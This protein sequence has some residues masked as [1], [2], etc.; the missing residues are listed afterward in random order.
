MP[1]PLANLKHLA[2][3]PLANLTELGNLPLANLEGLVNP[4]LANLKDLDKLRYYLYPTCTPIYS[5]SLV[6]NERRNIF[7][8]DIS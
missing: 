1:P 8:V 6:E 5:R 3:P 2:N 4:P 7:R